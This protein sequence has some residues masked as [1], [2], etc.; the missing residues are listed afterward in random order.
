M[1]GKEIKDYILERDDIYYNIVIVDEKGNR[2]SFDDI[3]D[4]VIYQFHKQEE[5]T[6]G[7]GLVMAYYKIK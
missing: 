2:L 4:N 1:S 5:L 6:I 3:Q 7:C